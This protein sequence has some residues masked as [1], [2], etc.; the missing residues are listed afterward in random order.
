MTGWIVTSDSVSGSRLIRAIDRLVS[1]QTSPRNWV[2]APR[3]AVRSAAVSVL[4]VS[5]LVA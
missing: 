3:C 4:V 2:N 5:V 1:T